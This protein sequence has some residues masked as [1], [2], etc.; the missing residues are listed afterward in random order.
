MS[1]VGQYVCLTI[2]QNK[3]YIYIKKKL[4]NE[5]HM[6]GLTQGGETLLKNGAIF[7]YGESYISLNISI[8]CLQPNCIY[9]LRVG[10]G[11][12]DFCLWLAIVELV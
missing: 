3:K 8:D 6:A 12:H 1:F 2:Q 5:D 9:Q 10:R 4:L 11:P 7:F